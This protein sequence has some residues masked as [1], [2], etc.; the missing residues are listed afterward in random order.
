MINEQDVIKIGKITKSRGIRGEVELLFTDDAFDRGEAEYLICRIEGILIPF[1]W[2]EYRFKNDTVAI[3]CFEDISD[4]EAAQK[5]VGTEVFYPLTFFK[6]RTDA[7]LS[8]SYFTG[9]QIIDTK[10][11][12]LG[13]V[14]SVDESSANILFYIDRE[15]GSEVLIP[16]HPELL[17]ESREA[18]RTLLVSL[19]E[20]LLSLND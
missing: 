15:D 11:G 5:I 4:E 17:V 2:K 20:G 3:F 16:F 19:P 6:E 12:Y 10:A 18:E 7:P 13:T 9:F 8:W 14:G 1:F